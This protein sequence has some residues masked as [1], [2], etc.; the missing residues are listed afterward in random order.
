[1]GVRRQRAGVLTERAE[2]RGQRA[3][4]S[5]M[6][7]AVTE[8]GAAYRF[9]SGAEMDPTV[10]RETYPGAVFMARARLACGEAGDAS[11]ETWGILIRVPGAGETRETGEREVITDDGHRFR[12]AVADDGRPTGDPA[13]VIAAA[14]YWELLP[15]YVRRLAAESAGDDAE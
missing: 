10:V 4:A 6:E 2:G 15:A 7:G 13:A 9:L 3:V 1:V 14:R 5:G 8:D 11:D 12:A